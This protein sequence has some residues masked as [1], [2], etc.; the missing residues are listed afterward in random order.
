MRGPQAVEILACVR[1]CGGQQMKEKDT[2]AVEIAARRWR[3]A[4]KDFRCE[5]HRRPRNAGG[6][7]TLYTARAEVH[8][9]DAAAVLAHHVL[10]FDITVHQ[11]GGVNR[12]KRSTKIDGD[13][14]RFSTTHRAVSTQPGLEG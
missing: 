13:S 1:V 5:I 12:C 8:Q 3:L 10:R 4:G 11:S 6:I 7:G 9:D 14:R 2:E